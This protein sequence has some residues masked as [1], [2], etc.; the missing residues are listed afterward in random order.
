MMSRSKVKLTIIALKFSTTDLFM[1]IIKIRK[2]VSKT[3][4]P[5]IRQ[6]SA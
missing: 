4:H 5:A 2:A 6:I 1:K 3:E